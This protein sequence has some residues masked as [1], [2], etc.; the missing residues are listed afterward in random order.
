MNKGK[1]FFGLLAVLLCTASSTTEELLKQRANEPY[2]DTY[3]DF[4][5]E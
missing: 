1:L 5:I 2:P 4:P 3:F